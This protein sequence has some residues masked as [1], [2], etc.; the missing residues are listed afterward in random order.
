MTET[1]KLSKI[2]LH[3]VLALGFDVEWKPAVYKGSTSK[4]SV[5]QIS[6]SNSA[7]ILQ[8][9]VLLNAKKSLNSLQTLKYILMSPRILKVGVGIVDDLKKLHFDYGV[10]MYV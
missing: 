10:Y 4:V 9:S 2:S 1:P 5:I 3:K 7:L 6:T 8:T